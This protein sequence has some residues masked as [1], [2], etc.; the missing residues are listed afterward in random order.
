MYIKYEGNIH[1]VKK[2]YSI[3]KDNEFSIDMLKHDNSRLSLKFNS[4]LIRNEILNMI[5]LELKKDSTCFDID[6]IA[7]VVA[8]SLKYKVL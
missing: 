7:D 1:N 5:W 4:E 3:V 6:E 2:Y 8:N